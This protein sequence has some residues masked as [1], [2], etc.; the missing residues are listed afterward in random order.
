MGGVGGGSSSG[1]GVTPEAGG[2]N[3]ETGAGVSGMNREV[4]AA[5]GRGADA[6]AKKRERTGSTPAAGM[7]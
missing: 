6:G 3:F 4:K 7:P 2:I 5:G 1:G